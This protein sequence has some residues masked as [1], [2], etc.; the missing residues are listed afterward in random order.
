MTS[1]PTLLIVSI[2]TIVSDPRVLKQVRLFRDTYDV[3]TC[4]LGPA[5][6]GVVRH[7]ELPAGARGWVNDRLSLLTRRYRHAYWAL[8]AVAAAQAALPVDFFDG[9]LANDLNTV[10]LALS[11]NPRRGVHADLHEFA[12]REKDDDLKWRLFVAPFMRWLCRT[13]LPQVVSATTVAPGIAAQYLHDY[14]VRF[15]V[16]TNAAPYAERDPRPVGATIRV[17][18]SAAGQ[19][20]RRLE[21]FIEAMRDAPEGVELDLIVVPNE[22]GYVDELKQLSSDVPG[23]RFREPVPYTELVDTLAD[24]DVALA[25]LPPT[26]FNLAHALPNKFFEAVQARLGLIIGPSPEMAAILTEHGLGL[27]TRDFEVASLRAALRG[28]T[29]AEVSSWKQAAHAAARSLS[30]EAQSAVWAR[31]VAALLRVA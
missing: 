4:G 24:Y 25:F 21:V 8:P 5:P 13:Y 9:V 11:L 18:H 12:P 3:Y 30:A 16:V 26:N 28:L 31:S 14:G 19:R 1:R 20:Y 6:E 17:I 2:S 7:Y 27:V 29:A 10:P 15:G 22:P 23:I